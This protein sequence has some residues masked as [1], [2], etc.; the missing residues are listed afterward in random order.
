M[1]A[2][3]HNGV[4]FGHVQVPL[5]GKNPHWKS[6]KEAILTRAGDRDIGARKAVQTE[7][8]TKPKT[9]A[10]DTMLSRFTNRIKGLG[11]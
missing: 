10:D 1:N 5:D 6:L 9:P 3:E 7:E 4:A 11:I 8:L 2:V